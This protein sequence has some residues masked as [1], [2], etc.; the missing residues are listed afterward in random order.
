MMNGMNWVLGVLAVLLLGG[1]SAAEVR[2]GGA[3]REAATPTH[4][5]V[6][7]GETASTLPCPATQ[8]VSVQLDVAGPGQP[9]P[10]LAVAPYADGRTLFVASERPG[11]ASVHALSPDGHLVS[12]FELT[13]HSDG[14]WPDSYTDCSG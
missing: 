3:P 10:E 7:V 14:W 5:H 6:A 4:P 8:Q 2:D 9:R 12:V 11:A 1:C 13:R